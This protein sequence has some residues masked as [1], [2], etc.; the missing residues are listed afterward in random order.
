MAAAHQTRHPTATLVAH[1]LHSS[2][3]AMGV[4]VEYTEVILEETE[5]EGEEE[6]AWHRQVAE[7]IGTKAENTGLETVIDIGTKGLLNRA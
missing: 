5:E 7:V 3:M 1:R 2:V 6:M 4:D